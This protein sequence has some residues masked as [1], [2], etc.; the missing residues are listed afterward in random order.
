[1]TLRWTG[2]VPTVAAGLGQSVLFNSH[3]AFVGKLQSEGS[4][5]QQLTLRVTWKYAIV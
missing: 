2:S 1:M 3:H 5:P 4:V